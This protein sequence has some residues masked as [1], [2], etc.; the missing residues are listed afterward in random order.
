MNRLKAVLALP[1]LF[2]AGFIYR[3]PLRKNRR[4]LWGGPPAPPPPAGAAQYPGGTPHD[5]TL[6]P[7]VFLL[8]I[9]GGGANTQTNFGPTALPPQGW[10]TSVQPV[11][12][13]ATGVPPGR[14][15]CQVY[16]C[17]T[18]GGAT[19]SAANVIVC[20]WSGYIGSSS[21]A[22][23]FLSFPL[24]AGANLFA[25]VSSGTNGTTADKFNVVATVTYGSIP[26]QSPSIYYAAPGSGDPENLDLHASITPATGVD[27]TITVPA[28]VRWH[29]RA[30]RGLLTANATVATRA[31]RWQMTDYLGH[32][33]YNWNF[34]NQ[35]WLAT[36]AANGSQ[37]FSI[38]DVG[39]LEGLEPAGGTTPN[40]GV[41]TV[42]L[43]TTL[44]MTAAST[45]TANTASFQTGGSGD[46]WS[47]V[48][49]WVE[50]WAYP[51]P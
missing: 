25:V 3:S 38:T 1:V 47:S 33:M 36:V 4:G 45:L 2:L 31:V 50:E 44:K 8:N 29:L 48:S 39:L 34:T 26:N 13:S 46:T 10:L 30:L 43:P 7:R 37:T 23:S 16:L 17:T 19:F 28:Q 51:Q 41:T 12:S 49:A 6:D 9:T 21:G 22:P 14:Y 35:S 27:L 15:Y 20:L 42:T 18:A 11:L 5:P 24:T 40:T 32:Q